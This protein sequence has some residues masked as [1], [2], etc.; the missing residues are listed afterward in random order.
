MLRCFVKKFVIFCWVWLD[1][2][3]VCSN[4]CCEV[5]ISFMFVVLRLKCF[6]I[7]VI[8]LVVGDCWG[9][10]FFLL[11]D[12]YFFV[13]RFLLMLLFC[14]GCVFF[15]LGD[16]NFFFWVFLLLLLVV[17]V[18]LLLLV[19]LFLLLWLFWVVM[20]VMLFI[21]LVVWFNLYFN[22]FVN[23]NNLFLFFWW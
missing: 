7:F 14:W 20:L 8:F 13:R 12:F 15:L 22:V 17:L 9:K 18:V 2:Y 6:K 1:V 23:W 5:L 19:L 3:F 11:V 16:F 10:V 4:L 21:M